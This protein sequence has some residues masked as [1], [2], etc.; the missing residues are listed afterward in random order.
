MLKRIVMLLCG[1]SLLAILPAAADEWNKKTIVTFAS[2]VELP[3]I[4]LPAGRYVFKLVDLGSARHIV[5]VTNVGETKIFAT[6]LA[7]P[8]WRLTPTEA[9]VMAFEERPR[10]NPPAL[11]AWFYPGDN[12]GQEFVYPKKRAAE[13]AATSQQLVLSGEVKPTEKP[14]ELAETHV[15]AV[16]PEKKEVEIA[17]EVQ[18]APAQTF[19]QAEPA[20]APVPPVPTLPKTASSLPTVLIL[21]LL[22]LGIAGGLKLAHR[23][24]S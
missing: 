3:G 23:R 11:R 20:Q 2:P 8:N 1:V 12:F 6:M 14:E 21:G 22:S 17:Q 7:I 15:V 10:G 16:T 18:P 19:A 13:L 4:V 24:L 5:R 9:T